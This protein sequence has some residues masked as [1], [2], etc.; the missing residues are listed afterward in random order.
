MATRRREKRLTLKA[1]L[2]YLYAVDRPWLAATRRPRS[3]A[4]FSEGPPEVGVV[5]SMPEGAL[6][7]AS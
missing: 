6:A 7:R 4:A 3:P 5:G 1:T 2:P